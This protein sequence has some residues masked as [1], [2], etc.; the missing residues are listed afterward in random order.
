MSNMFFPSLQQNK[1]FISFRISSLLAETDA[2]DIYIYW[3]LH[4]SHKF[5]KTSIRQLS[6]YG[7]L[8]SSC[9]SLPAPCLNHPILNGNANPISASYP[10]AN[11]PKQPRFNGQTSDRRYVGILADK[12]CG[13]FILPALQINNSQTQST[14]G[15]FITLSHV[16][17]NQHLEYRRRKVSAGKALAIHF[18]AEY[19]VCDTRHCQ[20][21]NSIQK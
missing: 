1:G 19:S 9:T 15:V 21:K 7:T 11:S 5:E 3:V 4:R 2:A 17:S 14:I 10:T 13:L 18:D 12:I 20:Y 8:F 16:Q 6:Y